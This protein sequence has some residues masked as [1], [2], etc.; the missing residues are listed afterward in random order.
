MTWKCDCCGLCCKHADR[1]PALQELALA[2]GSCMFL[3]NENKCSIY[4]HRPKVCNVRYIYEHYFEP[5]GVSEDEF[6][7][8]TQ[9]SCDKLKSEVI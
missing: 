5:K 9:E 7:A 8:K 6:Y 4:E 3:D 2:D 1:V